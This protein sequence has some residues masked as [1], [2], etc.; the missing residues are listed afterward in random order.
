LKM[1]RLVY[2]SKVFT[3]EGRIAKIKQDKLFYGM[4]QPSKI[5]II[6][7]HPLVTVSD[8]K[9][10]FSSLGRVIEVVVYY[11]T[12]GGSMRRAYVLYARASDASKAIKLFDGVSIQGCPMRIRGMKETGAE[13]RGKA[14]P[15]VLRRLSSRM[16]QI[17]KR[18]VFPFGPSLRLTPKLKHFELRPA[19]GHSR[20]RLVFE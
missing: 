15:V 1:S 5:L 10:F 18:R 3:C 12:S 17:S 2:L 11:S 19:L 9:K 16:L 4:S 8:V 13:V 6:N 14:I 20:S 7:L